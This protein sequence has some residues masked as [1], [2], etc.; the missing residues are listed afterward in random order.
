MRHAAGVSS[1]AGPRAA[2]YDAA[3]RALQIF[4]AL[5]LCLA[6][7]PQDPAPTTPEP[8]PT[9]EL[10]EWQVQRQLEYLRFACEQ[11]LDASSLSQSFIHLTCAARLEGFTLGEG[12][13]GDDAWDANFDKMWRLR[14]TSDFNA[15]RLVS[16]IY[17][18]DGHAAVSAGAWKKAKDA[19]LSFKYWSSDPTPERVVD[20]AQVVDSMWYWTENHSLIFRTTEYLA[21]QRWPDEAFA[22][23]GMKGAEHRDR[24]K[25]E[26]LAWLAARSLWGFN[27]WHS[28]VYYDLDLQPLLALVEWAEDEEVA[29]RA[30]MVL[31][32]FW[33]DIALHLHRGSFAGTHGRS[34]IKDKAA[35]DLG[36]TFDGDKLLFDDTSLGWVDPASH[37]AGLLSFTAAYAL[38][39]AIHEIAR[40]DAPL[41]DRERMNLPVD[42]RP[43]PTWDTPL[44]A[45]PYDLA[46]D[47][48]VDLPLWWSMNA[49]ASWPLFPLTFAVGNRDGLFASQLDDL[50]VLT[51]IV[52]TT[53]DPA[54]IMEDLHPLYGSFWYVL[55][56]GLLKE[57]STTT[58]RTAEY[59]LSSVQDYRKGLISDQVHPLQATLD[60]R[61]IVFI[62]Q[63]SLLPVAEGAAIPPDFNWQV[64]DEPG[65]GY[66]TGQGSLPRVA[67]HEGVAV[68]IYAPQYVPQPFGLDRYTYLDE[69]HAY[70][71]RAHFD[72]VAQAGPWT[73]G[74]KG[75][76]YVALYS[77]NPTTWRTGQ[78]E[79]YKNGD[80]PFDLVAAGAQNVWIVELGD[81]A[82]HGDFAAFRGKFTADAVTATPVTDQDDDGYDDGFDVTY[83]SP[84]GATLT[85]GWHAPFTVD[86]VEV[87]LRHQDRFDNPYVKAA[88]DTGSYKIVHGDDALTLDFSAS[89][90]TATPPPGDPPQ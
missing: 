80:Q 71:P 20:G 41:L 79:V 61:A 52:D 40:D 13:I 81:A 84:S 4:P 1:T 70:F 30:A 62:Q 18:H 2:P 59:M 19:L 55:N 57:V 58:Y 9:G 83:A 87:P 72:E 33:L 6:C 69:T 89:E 56:A 12:A 63:P 73:F 21:G 32:L 64:A 5:A 47:D 43:P 88:F 8:E 51:E 46:Y 25:A 49:F 35:A 75:D 50:A 3:M 22:V 15:L 14:D 48:E 60:E 29:R 44:V 77:Y 53:Q 90:R 31:D 26:I 78:P 86:G 24:A 68:A 67:Q 76:G 17:A 28:D 74:R 54:G 34:Y 85:F 82:T 27:E 23:T 11:P 7:A 36:D 39:W 16:L 45:P 42:E 10:A 65:P 66:W 37:L 38:P